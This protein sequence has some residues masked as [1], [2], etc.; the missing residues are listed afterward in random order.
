[1]GVPLPVTGCT[2]AAEV[3]ATAGAETASAAIAESAATK[4]AAPAT[5]A[6]GET[7]AVHDGPA[8]A[9]AAEQPGVEQGE[10]ARSGGKPHAGGDEEGDKADAAA[11]QQA[12]DGPP[13]DAAHDG[14]CDHH[15]EEQ[16]DRHVG[17]VEARR[18]LARC[19]AL[20]G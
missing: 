7:A 10:H 15:G 18:V 20:A 12:A 2:A 14:A 17:P 3:A 6:A 11:H 19:A 13:E 4:T 1:M 8:A 16:E 5:E 9:L